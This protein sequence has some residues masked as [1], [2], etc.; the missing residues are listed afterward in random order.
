[1]IRIVHA[2]YIIAMWGF[3]VHAG[4]LSSDWA[5]YVMV[6]F[7]VFHIVLQVMYSAPNDDA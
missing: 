3:G 1:M 2:M 5:F 7:V 6:A 4:I